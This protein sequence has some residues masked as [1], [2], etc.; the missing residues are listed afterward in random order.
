M[1]FRI[2]L[3]RKA[4]VCWLAAIPLAIAA[5]NLISPVKVRETRISPGEAIHLECQPD[6]KDTTG[7]IRLVRGGAAKDID[8]EYT[9][10]AG[11]SPGIITAQIPDDTAFGTYTVVEGFVGGKPI[12]SDPRAIGILSIE[13][14]GAGA[15]TLDKFDQAGTYDIRPFFAPKES[16]KE[17]E[18]VNVVLRGKGFLENNPNANTIWINGSRQKITWDGD[19]SGAPTKGAAKDYAVHGEVRSD[20]EIQLCSVQVPPDGRLAF[21]AGIGDT[22]SERQVLQVYSMNTAGVALIA[23]AIAG[24]LALLPLFLLS[25]VQKSYRIGGADYKLRMLFLD[26]ETDTYSLSK[27]QFYLWTVAA[28]FAYSY[29]FVSQVYVQHTGT[30]PDIPSNLPGIILV[31]AG[32]AVGAQVVT[33]SRGS[34]GAG[35]EEPSL[36][37]FI[38][39][40][41]VVAPDR[42][43]MFVWT[44]LGV[45][46]FAYSVLQKSPGLI[47]ELPTVP[48]NLLVMMGISSA[49]YLGGKM[50]RKAGPVI[51]Q[52]NVDP[53]DSDESIRQQSA[54]PAEMPDTVGAVV[55]AKA[56]LGQITATNA[57]AKAAI[58]AL[59]S[60]AD[61]TSAAH[62]SAEFNR[63]VADLGA[64]RDTAETSAARV[65]ADFAA[66][67]AAAAE[68]QA[69]QRAAAALQDLA[70]D[71]TTAI[72]SAALAPIAAEET[73]ALIARTIELRGTNLSP[74]AMIEIDD[75][76]LSYKMLF[77][78]EGD[79]APDVVSRD[80]VNPTFAKVLRLVID[81]A[82]LSGSQLDQVQKWFANGGT[83]TFSFLN[84]DGQRADM[85]FTIPPAVSQKVGTSQ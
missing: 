58:G 8:G 43:Q 19:C 60:A 6:L 28:L 24:G 23:G 64:F 17:I 74:D 40:G 85:S 37:D 9:P 79:N 14:P 76:D 52:I 48:N 78:R 50:A 31:A 56:E 81:P 46:A 69:A 45:G 59:K 63:L 62:T 4:A 3:G 33:S 25:F 41:G 80:D 12:L 66:D 55:R 75:A 84:P 72:A 61:A 82:R 51:N 5:D 22:R 15:T 57:D 35:D 32:T 2:R 65:A 18:T 44:I 34:K 38:T 20:R 7:K 1:S 47:T 77:N 13:P 68:A 21:E 71:V 16:P 27:L 70:A 36:A 26:T 29:L 53:P 11:A 39:S 10:G 83:H 67:Q 54:P 49:G 42:F 30:W 73:P